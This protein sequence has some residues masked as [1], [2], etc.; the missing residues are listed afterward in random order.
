M[1]VNFHDM[2]DPE[3]ECNTLN[4]A[5]PLI[6]TYLIII[7]TSIVFTLYAFEGYLIY[8]EYVSTT[9]SFSGTNL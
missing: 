5:Q 7:L 4:I 8:Y 3:L 2:V 9:S 1:D 6:K